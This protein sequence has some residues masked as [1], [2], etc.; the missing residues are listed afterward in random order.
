MEIIL[1]SDTPCIKNARNHYN[2]LLVKP[3]ASVY[4]WLRHQGCGIVLTDMGIVYKFYN[5]KKYNWFI[6]KW[7]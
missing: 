4:E 6:L 1:F 3:Y 7:G 5:K 2:T